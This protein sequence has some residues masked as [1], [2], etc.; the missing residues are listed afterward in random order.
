AYAMERPGRATGRFY[1]PARRR[2]FFDE[3]VE[4]PFKPCV[5]ISRTRLT[6]GRSS[7]GMRGSRVA[8]GPSQAIEPEVVEEVARPFNRFTCP[9]VPP[10]SLHHEAHETSLDVAVHPVELL[11]RVL[12][13]EVIAPSPK[14]RVHV[15]NQDA[16]V[17]HAVPASTGQHLHALS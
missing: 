15:V 13:A 7:S 2:F 5:R 14:D 4:P 6:D 11:R 12:R 17:L 8:Y 16:N 9:H 1:L 10:L 3:E